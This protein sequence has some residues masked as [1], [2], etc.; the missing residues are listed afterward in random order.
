MDCCTDQG[1][2]SRRRGARNNSADGT[3]VIARAGDHLPE[4]AGSIFEIAGSESSKDS[5]SGVCGARTE[6][7]A[8]GNQRILRP[9]AGR[10]AGPADGKTER[11]PGRVE[12]K[13]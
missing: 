10:V 4:P 11:H 8:G 5:I 13:L 1:E 3:R 12:R 6:N 7:A 2:N 9:A